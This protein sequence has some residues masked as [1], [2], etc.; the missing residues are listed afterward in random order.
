M[1]K[2]LI[3]S[4]KY[5][6]PV[7]KIIEWCLYSNNSCIRYIYNKEAIS[8]VN[9]SINQNTYE[10]NFYSEISKYSKVSCSEIKNIYYRNG[11]FNFN[12]NV[13]RYEKNNLIL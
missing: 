12:W 1:A 11:G 8:S 13:M 4:A 10:F 5:D 9:S 6:E 7:E 3:M 2:I